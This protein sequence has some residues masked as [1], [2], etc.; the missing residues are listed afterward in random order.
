MDDFILKAQAVSRTR[1]HAIDQILGVLT[2]HNFDPEMA[3]ADLARF[4]PHPDLD[5]STWHA[6]DIALFESLLKSE[7]YFKRFHIIAEKVYN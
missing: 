7:T 2:W 5:V 1:P 4:C 6:D 3:L